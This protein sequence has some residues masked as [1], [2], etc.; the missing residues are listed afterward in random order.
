[1]NPEKIICA[2]FFMLLLRMMATFFF[3]LVRSVNSYIC[4]IKQ[5]SFITVL[6]L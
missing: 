1:M 5:C 4:M 6:N 2:V 3:A